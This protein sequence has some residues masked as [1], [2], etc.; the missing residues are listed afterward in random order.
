MLKKNQLFDAHVHHYLVQHAVYLFLFFVLNA[1]IAVVSF[2][3][4]HGCSWCF[5]MRSRWCR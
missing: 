3:V 2:F 5:L 4:V 1:M